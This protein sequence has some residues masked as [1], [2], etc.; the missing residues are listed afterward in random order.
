M[1]Y[2]SPI[3]FAFYFRMR[4]IIIFYTT[5]APVSLDCGGTT[6]HVQWWL[7][8]LWSTVAPLEPPNKEEIPKREERVRERK[9][10]KKET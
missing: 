7:R 6:R 9:G 2:T 8:R 10:K 1:Y 4:T 5:V 3:F